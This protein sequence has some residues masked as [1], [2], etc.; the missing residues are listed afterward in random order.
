MIFLGVVD[1]KSF[2]CSIFLPRNST[3]INN[4]IIIM[5]NIC[6]TVT[7]RTRMIKQGT[8]VTRWTDTTGSYSLQVRDPETGF[9]VLLSY[10]IALQRCESFD[11]GQ[12]AAI[13]R[14]KHIHQAEDAENQA[15]CQQSCKQRGSWAD[16]LWQKR[17]MLEFTSSR[18]P[19]TGKLA[20]EIREQLHRISN[21]SLSQR[22]INLKSMQKQHTDYS[23]VE[24]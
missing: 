19:V 2:F 5:N 6:K 4:I 1:C 12:S 11:L 10:W 22:D 23:I 14:W 17:D 8:S 20:H 16:W 18:K 13:R 3:N 21:H 9:P 15:D 7:L 24:E